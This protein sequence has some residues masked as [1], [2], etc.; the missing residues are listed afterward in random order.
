MNHSLTINSIRAVFL[1]AAAAFIVWLAFVDLKL[2]GIS[3][4]L[5]SIAVRFSILLQYVFRIQKNSD[6]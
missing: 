3:A 1:L 5:F 6:T 2:L 4:L